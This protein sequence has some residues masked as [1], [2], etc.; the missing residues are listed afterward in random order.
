MIKKLLLKLGLTQK[1]IAVIARITQYSVTGCLAVV[2]LAWVVQTLIIKQQENKKEIAVQAP[3]L[4]AVFMQ[5]SECLL[6]IDI[7]AHRL[8]AERYLKNDQPDLAIPHLL[9]ILLLNKAN[10]SLRL[11]LAEAY[12]QSAQFDRAALELQKLAEDEAI[13]SL[14]PDILS[15]LG[16]TLFYL[17]NKKASEEQL[18]ACLNKYPRCAEASCFLGQV[19]ASDS[20]T[21]SKA[22]EYFQQALD[23]DPNYA[24][25]WYQ[26]GRLFMEKGQYEK[27]QAYLQH[28]LAIEPLNTRAHARLGMAYFYLNQTLLAKKEYETSLA[29]NPM[30]YNTHYNLGELLFT[31]YED[32][33][34]ALEEFKKTLEINPDHVEAN[35]KSG[36]ICLSNNMTKEAILFFEKARAK[37]PNNI[38]VLLQLGVAYEKMGMYVDAL[39]I[40]QAVTAIDPLN[41]VAGQKV[42]LLSNPTNIN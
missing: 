42:K 34:D 31:A 37:A 11:S 24:E 6:P 17:G 13:D 10:R 9:R 7:E 36:L 1:Q 14:T 39:K 26:M 5:K 15:K 4:E 30:D 8:T 16:L 19:K 22:Q 2:A 27:S 20:T 23:W 28:V 40:Y 25:A 35:F 29:L 21:A 41:Q 32:K 38:R 3:E 18:I 12:L 33:K